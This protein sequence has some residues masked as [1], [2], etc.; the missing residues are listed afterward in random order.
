MVH[1]SSY[2]SSRIF[3]KNGFSPV[4]SI[5]FEDYLQNGEVIFPTEDPH[6]EA[7]LFVKHI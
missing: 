3:K 6:T 2:F 7:T 4:F 1:A 5:K